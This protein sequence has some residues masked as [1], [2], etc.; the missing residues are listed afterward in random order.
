MVFKNLT[1]KGVDPGSSTVKT[2]PKAVWRTISGQELLGFAN[3][4]TG[5]KLFRP[6]I[7][8]IL[9]DFNGF[10]RAGEMCLVLGRPGSGCSSMLRALANQRG[11]FAQVEGDVHY[12]GIDA[13]EIAKRYRGEVVYVPSDDVHFPTLTVQQTLEFALKNKTQKRF[14]EEVD[15]YLNAFLKMFGIPHTKNTLV[16]DAYTRGVSGGERKRVSIA[17][18]LATRS[19]VVCWDNSTRG[20]DAATA[21]DYARSLRIM[22]DVSDR[23]T[24]TTLYQAG[25]TIYD[26][27]DKVCVIDAGKMIFFGNAGDAQAYFEE[28]GYHKPERQTTSDF[29]TAVTDPV[30]RRFQEGKEKTTP[31]GPDALEK[32]FRESSYFSRLLKDIEAYEQE[33]SHSDYTDASDFR[34][35]VVD[36]KSKYV[37][38]RSQYTVSFPRQVWNCTKRN[39][40]LLRGDP[41][42]FYTKLFV[43]ISN[44]FI[45]GSLFYGLQDDS[46]GAFSKGGMLFISILFPGWLQ[47]SELGSAVG[48]R[49]IIARHKEYTFYRPSAVSLARV[50]T[51]MPALAIQV[52]RKIIVPSRYRR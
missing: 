22:T 42:A 23:A 32:A 14:R 38:K 15:I 18:V 31:I 28:L 9:H 2:F 49:P 33:I 36:A 41:V 37:R 29:L 34:S 35:A 13:A 20:L 39:I 17:E 26:L 50:V 27:M 12:G 47:L 45:I 24:I 40:Q 25:Q 8:D 16:G 10:V 19:S 6:P 48:G 1:V 7:K 3:F 11:G 5:G 46:T 52:I 30:E 21:A 4:F 44:A 43:T 51:D